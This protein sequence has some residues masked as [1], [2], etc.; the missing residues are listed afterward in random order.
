MEA[1]RWEVK[2][3][4]PT[5]VRGALNARYPFSSMHVGAMW[6]LPDDVDW[7]KALEACRKV[8]QRKGFKFTYDSADREFLR[9]E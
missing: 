9:Y 6:R 1:K 2:Y 7:K 4:E 5:E 8:S 3:R